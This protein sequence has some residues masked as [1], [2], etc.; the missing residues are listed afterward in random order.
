MCHGLNESCKTPSPEPGA[1][2]IC[3]VI[4]SQDGSCGAGN[5]RYQ[6]AKGAILSVNEGR[7]GLRP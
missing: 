6:Q 7:A 2:S 5:K 4:S 3:W 1:F